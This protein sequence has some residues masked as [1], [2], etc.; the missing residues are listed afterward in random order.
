MVFSLVARSTVF[1]QGG[2]E[3]ANF[4]FIRIEGDALKESVGPW[5]GTL[6]WLIGSIALFAA[7]LGIIDH[8][9]RLVAD[10]LLV[11]Y[12]HDRPRWTE[13]RL[14]FAVVWGI[15]AFGIVV[16]LLGFDQPL[17]LVVLA[18]ALSGIVMF[19]YS[20]LL[21]AINRRFLPDR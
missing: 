17:T 19:I 15:I 3:E 16:L 12:F 13:S 8:V 21:I 2:F 10:V 4:D 14:Y 18:A 9:A 5:F 6:F 1:R 11:G 20:G 7:A